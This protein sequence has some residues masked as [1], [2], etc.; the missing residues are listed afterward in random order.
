[1]TENPAICIKEQQLVIEIPRIIRV[2]KRAIQ[3][4]TERR[5]RTTIQSE[6]PF[7]NNP[8]CEQV[9]LNRILKAAAHS[10]TVPSSVRHIVTPF[11]CYYRK[12]STSSITN[13]DLLFIK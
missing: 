1:M 7:S 6:L 11:I 3:V 9:N 4:L 13:I 12:I 2:T 8:I 10:S 5:K